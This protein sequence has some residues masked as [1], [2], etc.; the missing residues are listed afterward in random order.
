MMMSMLLNVFVGSQ[1]SRGF[2]IL[3]TFLK[4]LNEIDVVTLMVI[5]YF[6]EE[7]RFYLLR[8]CCYLVLVEGGTSFSGDW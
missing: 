8:S 5:A 6:I 4:A 7:L 1:V 3:S 2:T